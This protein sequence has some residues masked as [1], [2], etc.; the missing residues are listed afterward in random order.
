MSFHQA[1]NLILELDEAAVR[2]TRDILRQRDC[3]DRLS[4]I[5]WLATGQLVNGLSYDGIDMVIKDLDL[6]PKIDAMMREFLEVLQSFPVERIK[7]KRYHI[8]PYEELNGIPVAFMAR[9]E[10]KRK[11]LYA[12]IQTTYVVKENLVEIEFGMGLHEEVPTGW[13]KMG[14]P[15]PQKLNKNKHP[16]TSTCQ[17]CKKGIKV[18]NNLKDFY[19]E[20]REIHYSLNNNF[21]LLCSMGEPLAKAVAQRFVAKNTL[22]VMLLTHRSPHS[23]KEEKQSRRSM[24]NGKASNTEAKSNSAHG[25]GKAM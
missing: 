23:N 5:P 14:Y 7:S 8:V 25:S 9:I 10:K 22:K 15:L 17:C 2:C 12:S 18:Q 3:L 24:Y 1:L 19:E 13:Y 21:K 11:E 6:E 20:M 16:H 4:E